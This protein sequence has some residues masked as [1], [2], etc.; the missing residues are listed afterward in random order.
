MNSGGQLWRTIA[1][2]AVLAF[3]G[4]I[5]IL[6]V[7]PYIENWKLQQYLNDLAA[8]PATAK[9]QPEVVRVEVVKKA[10][11]LGLPVR[12]GDVRVTRS[13]DAIKVEVLY[14]V[15]V[16]V[17]LYTVDLHFRPTT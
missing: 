9:N 6:L 7:P 14:L 5:A 15:H 12:L 11:E 16:N 17:A 10:T 3:L 13:G 8:D 1:G 2:I 4:L